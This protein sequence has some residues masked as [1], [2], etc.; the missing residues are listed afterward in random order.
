MNIYIPST[1]RVPDECENPKIKSPPKCRDRICE[2]MGSDHIH[3][4]V[5]PP[6]LRLYILSLSVY[7]GGNSMTRLVSKVSSKIDVHRITA[8]PIPRIGI[9]LPLA[10]HWLH[11]KGCPISNILNIICNLLCNAV[12]NASTLCTYTAIAIIVPK[13][14]WLHCLM[15][16]TLYLHIRSRLMV[17]R[18]SISPSFP[19]LFFW[20]I[21]CCPPP[22]CLYVLCHFVCGSLGGAQLAHCPALYV[23]FSLI[24]VEW[25]T[26]W[27]YRQS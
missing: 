20:T 3:S 16:R 17:S 4:P 26:L 2:Q 11:P 22:F 23:I 24:Y 10:V 21:R 27:F 9:M 15:D 14:L 19:L 12:P 8:T 1:P 25:V 18:T 7:H 13:Y 6:T 5:P